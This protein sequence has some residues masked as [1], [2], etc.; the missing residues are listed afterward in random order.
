MERLQDARGEAGGGED[1][2]EVCGGGGGL[3]GGFEEYGVACE[4]GGD[5]GVDEDEVGV[6]WGWL[7]RCLGVWME[8]GETRGTYVPSEDDENRPDG[9]F[10]DIPLK[11]HLLLPRR[12]PQ[13]LLSDLKQVIPPLRSGRHLD[14]RI[15]DGTAHLLREFAG[16]L[17]F[18]LAQDV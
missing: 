3:G 10:P 15:S 2:D 13:R 16:V 18:L 8:G 1:G 17:I 6:L 5:E 12:I 4:E 9:E 11:P 7:A 14:P